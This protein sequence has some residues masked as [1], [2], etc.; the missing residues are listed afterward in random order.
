MRGKAR[1][2]ESNLYCVG[3]NMLLC[4]L[5]TACTR[6]VWHAD[7]TFTDGPQCN[8]NVNKLLSKRCRL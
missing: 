6:F 7:G 3:V 5:A 4:V 2:A 1:V 8:T